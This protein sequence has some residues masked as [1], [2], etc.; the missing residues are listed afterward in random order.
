MGALFLLLVAA[1]FAGAS[2]ASG[3][4][5]IPSGTAT[6]TTGTT[7]TTTTGTTTTVTTTTVTTTVTTTPRPE[8]ASPPTISGNPV[9]G[10]VLT[11]TRGE[12]RNNPVDFNLVWLRCA[13]AGGNCSEI[14]G[15]QGSL[16]YRLTSADVGNTVR[17]QVTAT[18]AG[19]STTAQSVPTAVIRAA[20]PT[21]PPPPARGAGCP[22]GRGNPDPVTAINAPAR[23][24][25]DRLQAIPRVVPAS[26]SSFV[27]R[28]HVTSSC[29]GNVQGALVYSTA[30]PYNMVS[31]PPETPTGRDGWVT[32]RFNALRD[33]PISPRQQLL[34]IFVRARKPGEN[35]LGGISTRRLVSVRVDTNR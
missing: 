6:T 20:T 19:G 8:L 35:V 24:L 25:V 3:G 11:G 23:L 7:G 14:S 1:G 18:N 9:A 2:I 31:I 17:F 32:L 12:W 4:S 13:A 5:A 21:P 26:A 34:V 16:Q 29:G 30:V 28:F 10:S 27:I 33:F 15:T 22:S